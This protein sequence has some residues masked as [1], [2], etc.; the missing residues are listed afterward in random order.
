MKRYHVSKNL[1]NWSLFVDNYYLDNST[2]LPTPY[3]TSPTRIATIT[4]I[5]VSNCNNVTFSFETTETVQ[6]FIYSLF[7]D[8]TLIRRVANNTNG[9][10]IDTS[11]GNKLYLCIYSTT[12]ITTSNVTNAMLNEGSTA[13]PYEP[14]G[15][16]W[17]TKSPPNYGTGTDAVT[18]LPV[19]LHTDGQPVSSYTLKGNTT[20]SGTPSPSNPITING[21][22]NKTANLY[23]Y[24]TNIS[25]YR[26]I[27]S[28]GAPYAD[29]SAIMSDYIPVSVGTYSLNKATFIVGYDSSKN[30]MGVYKDN[31]W[32]KESTLVTID[33]FTVTE[34]SGVSYIRF[35]S[36]T[37]YYSLDDTLMFNTGSTALP[38]EPYGY[39]ISILLSGVAL[40]PMYL[41]EQLMKIG[42]TVDSLVSTGTVT[43][44][45]KK[46]VFT[47]QEDWGYSGG[48]C[49]LRD[50]DDYLKISALTTICSHF[51]SQSN[52]PSLNDVGN[53]CLALGSG[54]YYRVFIRAV[55]YTSAANFK[56]YLSDQYAAGTPVT[57]YYI[58]ATPT[59]ESVTAPTITTTGGTD[60][61]D[62]DTTVKPSE[63]DLTYH[64]W[65]SHE[66][67]KRE[68]GQWS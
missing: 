25:G 51:Q 4:P 66:P 10:S 62:V 37:G 6:L 34:L 32:K 53:N 60:T 7:N 9:S 43:Y 13:Q 52:V 50:V 67:L 59:T 40:S 44:N 56:T 14:Y 58:L 8:N 5:D 36:Y 26:I 41:T 21:V 24:L 54:E 57:L 68:N 64:G 20:T 55:D 28:T 46:L 65:H 63:M 29:N 47:G 15:N 27:W 31:D 23:N 35:L 49:F 18:T 3:T 48:V 45:I 17:Q 11:Q 39:K 2:G 42:D 38:Y 22:G 30:Y 1:L 33:S 61:L 16:E 12:N 19:T